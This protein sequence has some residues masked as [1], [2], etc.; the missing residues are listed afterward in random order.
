MPKMK[1][2]QAQTKILYERVE[3]EVHGPDDPLTVE[4]AKYLLGWEEAKKDGAHDLIDAE[5]KR[6]R[7]AKNT[8]NR[9][10]RAS[11]AKTLAGEILNGRWRLNYEPL[12]FGKS[13]AIISAQ[14]RL[15]AL[16]LA[17]QE[18]AKDKDRWTWKGEP[19]IQVLCVVGV[20]EDD[21]VVNTIDTGVPR[22]L[23]DVIYRSP[24]FDGMSRGERSK[25]ARC[26]D[27]AVRLLW[28]RTGAKRDAFSPQRT[29]AESLD[30]L[31][32]HTKLLDAVKHTLIEDGGKG[33]LQHYVSPGY[34][35]GLLYLFGSSATDPKPYRS[36]RVQDESLL[37]FS[38]WRQA[39]TFF[40]LL[41]GRSPKLEALTV[42]LAELLDRGEAVNN[43]MRWALL[44]SA[45]NAW[46]DGGKVEPENLALEYVTDRN[47]NTALAEEP[48]C[49]GID[50]ID[51]E[52][53]V[54]DDPE[55]K[56]VDPTP[57]QIDERKV[58]A[59]QKSELKTALRVPRQS[60]PGWAAGDV[61][62]VRDDEPYLGQLA[63]EPYETSD[64][65]RR[66]LVRAQ[67]GDWEV[68]LA[69]LSLTKPDPKPLPS[70]SKPKSRRPTGWQVGMPCWVEGADGE[71]WGGHLVELLG[72]S[73]KIRVN[74]GFQGAG[75]IRA[76][77]VKDLS[78]QQPH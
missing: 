31:D 71:F 47:G 6:I 22:S 46:I 63:E 17:A 11:W 55:P 38:R 21:Q 8:M 44:V 62:W 3:I 53:P 51:E 68:T 37:D 2:E 33:K 45:W 23:A 75:S 28:Y 20:E 15:V 26:C 29:H 69:D 61:A 10:F 78:R 1:Q 57:E 66:V 49:G 4:D 7:L 48:T 43:S 70:A 19:T 39:Q 18:W 52:E 72:S 73:T 35:A 24:Y 76:V 40:V 50:S 30:F 9:P 5:G 60:G 34:A 27:Y 32:R 54:D 25:A 65:Q 56:K 12:L 58:K 67:D 42:S 36:A 64:G 74:Q 41:A 14:H 59:R 13:G 77:A 16:V